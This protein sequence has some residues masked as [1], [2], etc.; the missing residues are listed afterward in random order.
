MQDYKTFDVKHSYKLNINPDKSQ[1]KRL[2]RPRNIDNENQS[3]NTNDNH[4]DSTLTYLKEISNHNKLLPDD[5]LSYK[6]ENKSS[7]PIKPIGFDIKNPEGINIINSNKHSNR[8]SKR[9]SFY[10]KSLINDQEMNFS[11]NFF[12]YVFNFLRFNKINK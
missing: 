5:D 3:Q 12:L 11:K 8:K 2:W 7:I 6:Y 10:D 1:N 4:E 9:V